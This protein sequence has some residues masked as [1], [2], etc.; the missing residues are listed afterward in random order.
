VAD[1][2]LLSAARPLQRSELSVDLRRPQQRNSDPKD[3]RGVQQMAST[4]CIRSIFAIAG[5]TPFPARFQ[6]CGD[7]EDRDGT[8]RTLVVIAAVPIGYQSFWLLIHTEKSGETR[9][10]NGPRNHFG[11]PAKPS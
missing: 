2:A 10:F 7:V 1:L 5:L 8:H 9:P 11:E 6:D 4:A 3:L